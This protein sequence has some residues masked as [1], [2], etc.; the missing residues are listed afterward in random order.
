MTNRQG[1]EDRGRVSAQA[2]SSSDEGELAVRLSRMA[3]RLQD[4]DEVEATLQAITHAAVDTIPGVQYAAMSLVQ[5]RKI[6]TRAATDAVARRVD[7]VQYETG[8]GPCLDAISE[9]R[10]IRLSNLRS[11][12]RWPE[13]T[14]RA[15][16]L[17]VL[18]MLSFQLF[19]RRDSMGA[20]NLYAEQADAFTDESE[21]V[22]LLFAAHAAV[23][24]SGAQH[25]ADLTTALGARDLIGQ[26]KR[27]PDG[28]AQAD[29]RPGVRRAD[30]RQSGKQHQTGG[31]RAYL[32][33]HRRPRLN[34]RT[35]RPGRS[36]GSAGEP[37]QETL[38]HLTGTLLLAGQ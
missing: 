22:G 19:V 35:Y 23:A 24:L 25:Q 21:H 33:Q 36:C 12:T 28:T 38:P 31:G 26:A 32:G 2:T 11:E 7:E 17:G 4:E 10:T 9:Q 14:E 16:G 29:R 15:A 6:Q 20:L 27:H 3:R 8:Q 37:G 18:S 5:H 34:S 1:G 13:F 30:P